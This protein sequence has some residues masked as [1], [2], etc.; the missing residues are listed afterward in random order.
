MLEFKTQA[1]EKKDLR[2]RRIIV[3]QSCNDKTVAEITSG[4][5]QRFEIDCMGSLIL[6]Q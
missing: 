5:L 1:G 2:I 3:C 6:G 4:S